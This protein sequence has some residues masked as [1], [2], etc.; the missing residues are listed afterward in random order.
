MLNHVAVLL[1]G[2][3]RTFKII[4]PYIFEFY[5]K[6]AKNVDYYFI[7]WQG[8]QVNTSVSDIFKGENLITQVYMQPSL[9][10]GAD[11]YKSSSYLAYMLLPYK[12]AREKSVHYDLVFDTRPDVIP[13]FL[14]NKPIFAPEEKTLYTTQFDLHKN[15]RY[16]F[17]DIALQDWFFAMSSQV[18]DQMAERFICY[19]DQGVQIAIRTYAEDNG[20]NVSKMPYMGYMARPNIIDCMVD[21]K[22]IDDVDYNGKISEW[23]CMDSAKKIEYCM[24]LGIP[25]TDY[26]TGSTTCSI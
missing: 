25:L 5:K 21:N 24:K 9:D 13:V 19:N 22:L 6:I 20:I 26:Q 1:R 3:V 10:Y 4:Y 11:S 15:F 14:D 23:L 2:H 17:Y 12:H 18:Y 7:T 8:S 16:N